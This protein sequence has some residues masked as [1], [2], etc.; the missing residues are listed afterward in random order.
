MNENDCTIL[1]KNIKKLME[2]VQAPDIDGNADIKIVQ[3]ERK[4]Y[5]EAKKAISKIIFKETK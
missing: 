4:Q 1:I 5:F 2:V 3:E